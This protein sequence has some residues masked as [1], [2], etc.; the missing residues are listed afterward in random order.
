MGAGQPPPLGF[1]QAGWHS[2]HFRSSSQPFHADGFDSSG[3][4]PEAFEHGAG[5][6]SQVLQSV[7]EPTS[8]VLSFMDLTLYFS[9]MGWSLLHTCFKEA[10]H[11]HLPS[12]HRHSHQSLMPGCC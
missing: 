1:E 4:S 10:V 2:C 11:S 8:L 12:A 7:Y 5:E 3:A 9:G 6:V